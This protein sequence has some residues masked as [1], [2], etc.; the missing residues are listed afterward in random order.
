MFA[1]AG[2]SDTPHPR[3]G[4]L[5][6]PAAGETHRRP[7]LVDDA[8]ASSLN[9]GKASTNLRVS[10][11]ASSMA[12]GK[13]VPTS[14]PGTGIGTPFTVQVSNFSRSTTSCPANA[15]VPPI[16]SLPPNGWTSPWDK[17]ELF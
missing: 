7:G 9:L 15:M 5:R 16:L 6:R 14:G 12:A 17:P 4:G 10:I 11:A 8:C 3:Q 2:Q 1:S 13:T